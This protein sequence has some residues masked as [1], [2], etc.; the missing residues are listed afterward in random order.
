[1]FHW[2]RWIPLATQGSTV[3]WTIFVIASNVSLG[4]L[5]SAG[6]AGFHRS[7]DHF[8]DCLECFIGNAAID[9]GAAPL[10]S[11]SAAPAARHAHQSHQRAAYYGGAF[12]QP[13]P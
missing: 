12:W 10:C 5:D 7:L 11:R 2:E 1:M 9:P 3:L 8:C 4:T 6:H 13:A